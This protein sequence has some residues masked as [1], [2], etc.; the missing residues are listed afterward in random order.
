MGLF[1][2]SWENYEK[3]KTALKAIVEPEARIMTQKSAPLVKLTPSFDIFHGQKVLG[4][5]FR[6]F[7]T[8]LDC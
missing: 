1:W 8:F 4:I 3:T 2:E 6:I 5:V 7:S